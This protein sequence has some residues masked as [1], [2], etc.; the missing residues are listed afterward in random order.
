MGEAGMKVYRDFEYHLSV[1]DAVT[2]N[3]MDYEYPVLPDHRAY[4]EDP[5]STRKETALE[6]DK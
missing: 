1:G 3:P 4:R 2:Q 5:V 6:R